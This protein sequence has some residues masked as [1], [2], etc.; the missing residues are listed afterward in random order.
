M[1]NPYLKAR[2]LPAW[3]RQRRWQLL[4]RTALWLSLAALSGWLMFHGSGPA[5][6]E[7]A[8]GVWTLVTVLGLLI[9]MALGYFAKPDYRALARRIEARHP[10][11]D[12]RLL[13]AVEVNPEEEPAFIQ[14]RLLQETIQHGLDHDWKSLVRPRAL[15]AVQAASLLA[16]GACTAIF[17]LAPAAPVKPVQGVVEDTVKLSDGIEVTPGDTALEK[18]SSLLVMVRF[19]EA[20]PS[21][22]ELVM[23]N[24]PETE[25]RQLLV[26]SLNDP[27]FGGSVPDVKEDF[28]YR[29]DYDGKRTRDFSVKVFEFPKLE[30]SD[31]TLTYPAW[32]RLPEKRTE[33]TRR[34]SAVEGTRLRLDLQLNKPVAS[35]VLKPREKEAAEVPLAVDPEKAIATLTAFPLMASQVYELILTDSD[36]RVNKVPAVFTQ[37]L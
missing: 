37:Y 12:G 17:L 35:A 24:T 19:T 4:S 29:I 9:I 7:G 20:V 2:L 30:R 11:L 32:T 18:G 26:R 6:S 28:R 27:V 13:T 33:D 22:V 25:R 36:Q 1:I 23:G 8:L 3:Q 16:A 15:D 21:T 14:E 31:V 5:G 34:A 10:A